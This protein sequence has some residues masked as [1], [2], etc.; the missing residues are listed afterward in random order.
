MLMALLETAVRR[1]PGKIAVAYG[2]RRIGY[3]ELLQQVRGCAAGLRRLGIGAGDCVALALHN[4]PEFLI[5]FF[6]CAG[7]RAIVLPVNPQYGKKEVQRLLL[8]GKPKAIVASGERISLCQ[9]IAQSWHSGI[10][11][12][13]VE[14]ATAGTIPFAP[15]LGDPASGADTEPYRGR[16]LYLYTS[17]STD[18]FK[19]V[20]CTQE[21][22]FYEAHNF[23]ASTGI[24][25][26]DTILCTI[27]LCHSYGLGN[28]LLDAVYAGATL[29]IEPDSLTPFAARHGK[30][31][32]LLGSERIRIYPGVPFQFDVLAGSTE[33]VRSAF[34]HVKWCVSSGDILPKR[35]FDRFRERT[36]HPIR[37]LYGSTEAGS[38]A[39]NCGAASDLEFGS[40]GLPLETATAE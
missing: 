27:P 10:P 13:A 17:G 35:T 11:V 21:N 2:E 18:T 31:L 3:G 30:M 28:C 24:T 40:L 26:D 8:D 5:T 39:M 6:A 7:L 12:I 37:S 4:C 34:R 16:A 14:G 25:A 22:L 36:G 23:V 32:E 38:I 19:R 1:D 9:D 29:V 15:I 33:D 20:C